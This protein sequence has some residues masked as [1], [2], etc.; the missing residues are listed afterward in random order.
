M[1]SGEIIHEKAY[2]SPR[3]PP[4]ISFKDTWMKEL[5]SEVAGNS[6]DTERIQPEPKTKLSRTGRPVGGQE[7]TKVEELDIDFRV[8]RLSHAIVKEAEHFPVQKLLKKKIESHPRREAH[9]ADLQ[10]NN[11]YNPFSNNSKAMIRELGNVELF[12]LCETIP[13][14]QC[15]HCLLFWNQGIICCTCGQFLVE[16][17]SRRK[18]DKRRLDALSIPH[19]VI[20]TGL[21]HGARHGKTEEQKEYH[22]AWHAWKRCSKKVVFQGEH[23]TGIH[24]R[25]LRDPVYRASQLAIGWTEQKCKEMDELAKENHTYH[26]STE[27]SKRYQGQWYL[28]LNKSGKN[29]PVGLRPDFRAAVSLKNRLHRVRRTS[30]RTLLHNNTGDGILLQ[31]HHGGA[32]LNGIG[33][34][35]TSNVLRDLFVTVGFVYSR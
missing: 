26:L 9:Q 30:C 17:E 13:K 4:T 25:Y 27:E 1:E 6:K 18:F 33:S 3:P 24:D 20:K 23:F 21:C 29:G 31:A 19:Y 28:T 12:E 11:V 32:G 7:S 14:V 16:S 2:V 8:P 34:E 15:S 5:D 10:Q 22:E 35:L